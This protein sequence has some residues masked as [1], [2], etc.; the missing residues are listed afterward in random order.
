V[1]GYKENEPDPDGRIRISVLGA[2]TVGKSAIIRRYKDGTFHNEY[3]SKIETEHTIRR[4]V[5]GILA[6]LLILDPA[7]EVDQTDHWYKRKDGV[8]LVFSM[9]NDKSLDALSKYV[10][11]MWKDDERPNIFLVGNKAD[12]GN[13]P[14]LWESAMEKAVAWGAVDA[15]KTSACTG[16]NIEEAFAHI[17]REIRRGRAK[18]E[19]LESQPPPIVAEKKWCAIL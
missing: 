14:G 7:G 8:M 2:K 1:S 15:K 19:A 9:T 13:P 11:Q 10:T 12:L 6:E 18:K 5:D 3:D 17:I 16:H 4:Y